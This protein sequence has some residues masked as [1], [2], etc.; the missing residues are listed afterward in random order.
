MKTVNINKNV[1]LE[2]IKKN[3]DLHMQEYAAAC[4]GYR[5]KAKLLL[6]E[7]IADL[8]AGKTVDLEFVG[9]MPPMNHKQAYDRVVSMLE[10]SEDATILLSAE[11]FAQYM[12]DQWHWTD[13]FKNATAMY[14]GRR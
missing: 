1:L 14:S 2:N 7:R 8:D 3:R 4:E 12:M 9:V 10:Y 6:Q 11:D 13:H 5:V